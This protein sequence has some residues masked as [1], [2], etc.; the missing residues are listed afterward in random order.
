MDTVNKKEWIVDEFRLQKE[1]TAE[2]AKL[3]RRAENRRK[4]I[5]SKFN[6]EIEDIKNRGEEITPDLRNKIWDR[7]GYSVESIRVNEE[8]GKALSDVE[9][10]YRKELDR[11]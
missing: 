8:T 1:M 4:K 9:E 10:K 2:I 7:G 6:E 3:K 5:T 11:V